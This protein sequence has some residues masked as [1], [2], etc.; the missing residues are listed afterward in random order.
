MSE[1]MIVDV[2]PGER[3]ELVLKNEKGY[4]ETLY[5]QT[6]CVWFIVDEA[7]VA[8]APE[9][10][11]GLAMQAYIRGF[12][13]LEEDWD[14]SVL[15][16]PANTVKRFMVT[17]RGSGTETLNNVL[18]KEGEKPKNV[19]GFGILGFSRADQELVNDSHFW[20]DVTLRQD[21][22]D[23][24]VQLLEASQLTSAK[25][26]A[27][28]EGLYSDIHPYAPIS[29]KS[30]LFLPPDKHNSIESPD[31]AQGLLSMFC[32][33]GASAQLRRA[34]CLALE[35]GSLIV[36]SA[37]L[38]PSSDLGAKIEALRVTVKWVVGL[39]FF[40]LLMLVLK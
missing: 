24:M 21:S 10:D 17:M 22:L 38:A 36:P 37:P 27:K 33:E 13:S 4:E 28:F 39:M 11:E 3:K 12:V 23:R 16:D 32:L 19:V 25:F 34:S 5:P 2:R 35:E 9:R 40:A 29:V 31:T 7:T 30:H 1:K 8:W 6:K 26:G 14:L 18:D 20:L 15:G